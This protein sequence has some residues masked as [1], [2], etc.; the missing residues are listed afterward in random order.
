MPFGYRN[1][2]AIFQRVMQGV[3]APFLWIFALIYIDD[4][5]IY[6]KTFQEHL[7][8]LDKVFNV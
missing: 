7:G 4:I 6:S 5:V 1:G 3:L 2:P 8:Y